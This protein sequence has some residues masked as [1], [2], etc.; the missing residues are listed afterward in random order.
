MRKIRY[1]VAAAVVV[2]A[3]LSFFGLKMVYQAGEFNDLV[4]HQAGECRL[5]TGLLGSEDLTIDPENGTAYISSTDFRSMNKETPGPQG[6]IWAYRLKDES[7]EPVNLTEDFHQP[8]YPHGLGLYIGRDGGRALF[9]VN[10]PPGGSCV[11]IFDV[12]NGRLQHRR[13]VRDDRMHSPND[14]VPVGPDRFYVTVDHGSASPTIK[15][16][17]DFLQLSRGYVLYFDGASFRRVAGGFSYANGINISPDGMFVYVGETVGRKV[18][19]F[20]RDPGTGGLTLDQAID[21][22]TGVDN[23][24]VD[25]EGRL[26]LGAHPK[27]LT[28]LRYANDPARRAPAQVLTLTL[29]PNQSFILVEVYLSLG[30]PLSGSSVATVYGDDLL[31]GSV[32]DDG[33]LVCRQSSNRDD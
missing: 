13:T 17:E 25:P 1:I 2:M 22:K 12:I 26:W 11:E 33:F 18:N 20:R 3:A 30:D 32:F 10:H 21:V 7:P 5:V 27:L 9:V 16:L 23:I 14:L 6:A 24:E 28:F 4:P 19:V 31:I 29:L 15:K 8:L